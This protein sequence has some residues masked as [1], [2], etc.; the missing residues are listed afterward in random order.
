M[1][2]SKHSI[3]KYPKALYKLLTVAMLLDPRPVTVEAIPMRPAVNL[4]AKSQQGLN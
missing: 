4:C 3:Q 2:F 1:S